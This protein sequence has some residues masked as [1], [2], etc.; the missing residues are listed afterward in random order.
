M[1]KKV[2]K[3]MEN[4]VGKKVK[5]KIISSPKGK[6]VCPT[7]GR[8]LMVVSL[9]KMK[10]LYSVNEITG[11]LELLEAIQR[12]SPVEEQTVVCADSCASAR[13]DLPD[14]MFKSDIE[15]TFSVQKRS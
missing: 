12:N 10:C 1:E 2:G 3:K 5:T 6:F 8:G 4:K 15:N 11:E 14:V 7:C 13:N 9:E